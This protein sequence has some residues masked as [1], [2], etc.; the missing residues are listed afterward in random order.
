MGDHVDSLWINSL[1]KDSKKESKI[2]K[3]SIPSNF[4]V[5]DH[6]SDITSRPMRLLIKS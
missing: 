1:I 3:M 6:L 2:Q 5:D 4:I